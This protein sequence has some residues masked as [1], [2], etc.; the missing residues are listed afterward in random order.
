VHSIRNHDHMNIRNDDVI[1]FV[2]KLYERNNSAGPALGGL[3]R[4]DVV[5]PSSYGE[6]AR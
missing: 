3:D 5:G 4:Y 2:V 6:F 1:Q